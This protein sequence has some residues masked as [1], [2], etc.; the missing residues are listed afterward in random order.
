MTEPM[1]TTAHRQEPLRE[2]A[3]RV[4]RLG[5]A[6][7]LAWEAAPG[8]V[9]AQAALQTLS[10]AL[11]LAGLLFT[12]LAIDAVVAGAAAGG[13]P[14]AFRHALGW[15]VAAAA[16][17][18]ASSALGNLTG[19]VSNAQSQIVTDHVLDGLH[20]RSV[21]IDLRFYEDPAYHDTLH[22][23]LQE[24]PS[25]PSRIVGE[26]SQLAQSFVGLVAMGGF[27]ATLRWWMTGLLLLA[28]IPGIAVRL[29][30]SRKLLAFR[31]EVTPD[32]RRA[33]YHHWLMTGP[34]SAAELRLLGLGALF[35][36]RSTEIRRRLR[37]KSLSL[38]RRKAAGEALAQAAGSTVVF[39][40]FGFLAYQAVG[41]AF[42]V[43]AFVAYFQAF[44]R[45]LG[46]L[47]GLLGS[48]AGLW[49]DNLFLSD[50]DAFLAITPNVVEP[51][52]PVPFPRP[53]TRGL[54][55]ESVSFTYRGSDSPAISELSVCIRPGEIVALVGP[56]GSGKTTL[57]KLL[58]R[59]YDP[60][61]GR[62]TADGVDLRSLATADLRRS[63]A[64]LPQDFG[65]YAFTARENIWLGNT[66][67]PSDSPRVL[68]AAEL[69]GAREEVE[70]L[71]NRWETVLG[72]WFGDGRD[73]S[74]GQWQKIALARTLFRNA[75]IVV[76]DE[77][78]SA[79]DPLA[80]RELFDR[81]RTLAAG[82]TALFI[83]HRFSTVRMADRI[84]V[85]DQGRL[86]EDG[87]DEKLRSLGG[88][89]ARMRAAQGEVLG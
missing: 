31:R 34:A 18:I 79:L 5:R 11:P 43:G 17:T 3:R 42:T 32:E 14:T 88:L 35:R 26:L 56:N 65:R 27:L 41:G 77:P 59:L 80:E 21:E 62:I 29:G 12:K 63:F 87:T 51:V 24:A 70:A 53:L 75:P 52:Q 6:F 2:K 61:A 57:V 23:A 25:R 86:V 13:G 22:R 73:L 85:L 60:D 7:R 89:Y 16:V 4:L 20:R 19:V 45:G 72:S 44:Q 54:A 38:G 69:S 33:W 55:L 36:G 58:L 74:P 67:A 8:L 48:L 66:E 81:F 46:A 28:A 39:G 15:L 37:E 84:L 50:F 68:E 47:Q 49:E 9:V 10:G 76:L 1:P 40:A 71:P 83:S 78:S 82:R 30:F 64:V